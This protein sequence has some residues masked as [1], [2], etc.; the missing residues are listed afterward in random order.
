MGIF[1]D[2]EV[3]EITIFFEEKP[4]GI[5]HFDELGFEEEHLLMLEGF[6]RIIFD[7]KN[8]HEHELYNMPTLEFVFDKNQIS[9][10]WICEF[11]DNKILESE[12]KHSSKVTLLL[13]RKDFEKHIHHHENQLKI[14]V[15]FSGEINWNLKESFVHFFKD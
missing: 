10:H 14:H 4:K 3:G 1:L 6:S 12:H 2:I 13:H 7:F 5:I 9:S 11:N 15:E 8:L